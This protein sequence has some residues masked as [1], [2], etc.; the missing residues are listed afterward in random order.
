M[1]A[2]ASGETPAPLRKFIR[3]AMPHIGLGLGDLGQRRVAD[4]YPAT[5]IAVHHAGIHE[6]RCPL[7]E[8][9]ARVVMRAGRLQTVKDAPDLRGEAA[10]TG[11]AEGNAG[12]D[13]FA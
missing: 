10:A 13:A 9:L 5:P 2:M 6:V 12:D 4:G 3:P 11:V 7:R 8:L 1:R